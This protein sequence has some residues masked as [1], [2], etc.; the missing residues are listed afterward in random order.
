[1]TYS[2]TF[3]RSRS[4]E[5]EHLRTALFG[6]GGEG[7]GESGGPSLMP[8]SAERKRFGI[9]YTPPDFTRFIVQNTVAAVIDQR[10]E[11]LR[12]VRGL[13]KQEV[14]A[15][16]PS[17]ALA[18]Y[19]QDCWQALRDVKVCDPACGSG[20]FLIQAYEVL[21]ERYGDVADRLRAQEGPAAAALQESIPDVILADNL[22]GADLS[23]QAVE[24][25][26]ARAMDSVGASRQ[27]A[28][29]PVPEHR[30]AQ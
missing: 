28:G 10:L 6:A 9:Y 30:V 3:S 26:R 20:A 19:W 25:T 16:A 22:Y 24:I 5:L 29:R 1:M 27:N 7:N 11:S 21:E 23:E 13:N 12:V 8:K 2:G 17:P 4:G 14:E 18:A 15:D